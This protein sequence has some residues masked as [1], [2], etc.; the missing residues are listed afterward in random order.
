MTRDDRNV[1]EYWYVFK[2]SLDVHVFV[3]VCVCVC[4]CINHGNADVKQ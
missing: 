1:A 3:S 2:I 4:V